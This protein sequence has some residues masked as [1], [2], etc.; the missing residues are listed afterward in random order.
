MANKPPEEAKKSAFIIRTPKREDSA[1]MASLATQLGYPSKPTEIDIRIAAMRD[2][3]RFAVYVAEDENGTVIGW[4]SAFVFNAIELDACA[5]ING[6]VVAE[7]ARSRGAGAGLVQAVEA[8][9]T[10]L[11]LKSV[12]VRSNVLRERAHRFY[13]RSGYEPI[14]DQRVFLKS[15]KRSVGAPQV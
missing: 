6:L 4:I 8:W 5:E 3:K 2:R 1:S 14:K 12:C 13:Q 9:A 10:G 7:N 15:L 11:E